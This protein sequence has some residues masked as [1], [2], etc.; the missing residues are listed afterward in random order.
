MSEQRLRDM[1]QGAQTAD[2]IWASVRVSDLKTTLARKEE[3]ERAIHEVGQLFYR[4]DLNERE[5]QLRAQ[6]IIK[7]VAPLDDHTSFPGT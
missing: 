4:A 7:R 6:A 5:K 3:L 2:R 1:L